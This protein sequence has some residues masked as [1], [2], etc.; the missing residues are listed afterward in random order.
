MR[1]YMFRNRWG[2]LFFVAMTALGGAALVGGEDDRGVLLNAA[3]DLQRQQAAMN[4]AMGET[5]APPVA[6][7]T[8]E[9]IEFTSDE[10]LIDDAAGIDP[11]PIEEGLPLA[12]EVVPQDE[13]VIVS[14]DAGELEQ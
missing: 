13:V 1:G 6:I 10:E 12:A 3:E 5:T 14:R 9:A 2:A 11:T 8:A 7:P 4:A